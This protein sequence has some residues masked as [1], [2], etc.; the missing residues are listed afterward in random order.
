LTCNK[1]P[2]SVK[3]LVNNKP[4]ISSYVFNDNKVSITFDKASLNANDVIDVAI[5]Y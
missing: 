1:K 4:V 2:G 3:M 5:S